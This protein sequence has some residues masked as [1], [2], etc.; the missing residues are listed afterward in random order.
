ML[1]VF[2]WGWGECTEFGKIRLVPSLYLLSLADPDED[3]VSVSNFV[4]ASIDV[5]YRWMIVC[6]CIHDFLCRIFDGSEYFYI[7]LVFTFLT[8]GC[9]IHSILFKG[10]DREGRGFNLM[11]SIS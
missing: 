11:E 2:V 1:T 4:F 5:I 10:K 9:T 7:V 8:L 3:F 6:M